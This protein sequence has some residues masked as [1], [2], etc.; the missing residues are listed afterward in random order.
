MKNNKK[1]VAFMSIKPVYANKL[2]SG[3]KKYEYRKTS[4]NK[5]LTHIIIY[6][7]S[8][9]KKILGVAE[10]NGIKS[11]S[12]TA[13]W[14][15]TKHLGGISRRLFREYFKNKKTAYAIEI[16]KII[17]FKA[18]ITPSE[19]DGGFTVPQTFSY[20]SEEFFNRVL[21]KGKRAIS[22]T[23][24]IVL[25]G[26]I[27]GVGKSTM[28]I[29]AEKILKIGYLSAGR[30]IEEYKRKVKKNDSDI[31]KRVENVDGNQD[32][33]IRAI[34]QAS[35]TV[36]RCLLDGHF[37]LI[38]INGKIQIVPEFVFKQINPIAILILVDDP[39]SIAKKLKFRDDIEYDAKILK[40][41]QEKELA[42]AYGVG[43]YLNVDVHEVSC[44]DFDQFLKIL[45]AFN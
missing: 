36:E 2:I 44:D 40:S 17:P 16:K 38:D 34:N 7:T 13:T 43:K 15:R 9:E 21:I 11:A 8:P 23:K 33:L 4:I 25:V 42:Q 1:I 37:T 32:I 24:K 27:H 18:L 29:Q 35:P 12:P 6:S 5:A 3:E 10:V 28:C 22:K 45:S 31:G 30:L 20:V 14:E 39:V 26:G 41:M 19:I